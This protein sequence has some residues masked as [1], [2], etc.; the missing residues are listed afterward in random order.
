[1]H[2]FEAYTH[3]HMYLYIYIYKSISELSSFFVFSVQM[4]GCW[5]YRIQAHSQPVVVECTR[6]YQ[7]QCSSIATHSHH[8]IYCI[9]LSFMIYLYIYL[10]RCLH[11]L[12]WHC[13]ISVSL[14]L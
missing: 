1:M 12:A 5:S 3:T 8:T 10:Y 11:V 2:S 9:P 13:T 6:I 14:F 4:I 7:I